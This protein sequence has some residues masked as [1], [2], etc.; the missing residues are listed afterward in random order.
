MSRH[1]AYIGALALALVLSLPLT[2]QD[3]ALVGTIKDA[4]GAVIS[5]AEITLTNSDTGIVQHTKSDTSGDYAFPIVKPGTYGVK[6]EQKGFHTFVQGNVVLAVEARA[7]LDATL[8]VGET[9][10]EITVAD[11]G[12]G[13][14]TETSSLGSVVE[15]KQIAEIPLNGRFFLDL[16]LLQAGTVVPSTN[17]RTFLAVPSGI[18]MSGINASGTREDSTNYLVDGINVSDMVQ[19]QI[20]FQPNI[21]MIQEFKVQTNAFSAEYGRNAGI[22]INAVSKSGTNSLHG[23][24]YEFLRNQRFDAKNFF[25]PAGPIIPFNRNIFGYSVGGP[26]I[27]NRTFFFSSYEGRRAHEV[28]SLKTQ[29]PSAA[30]RATVTN[31][32]IQKLLTLVPAATDSTGTFFIGPTP[33]NRTLNQFT[34]RIDHNI[35]DH[36]FLFGSFISNHDQRTEP[37]LQGN[38]LPGY[39]DF[40]PAKRYLLSLGY[41]HIFSSTIT[42]ELRAG[43]NRV[44]I[45]FDQ[46]YAGKPSDFGFSS[47]S[48]VFPEIEVSGG[49]FFGGI[50]GFPQGRGDTTFHYG[51]TV[52]LVKGK[53]SIKFGAE[54]RRFRNNN[55]NGG[56]GGSILFSSLATFLA[57]TPSQDIETALPA[58]PGL[59]VNALGTFAQDDIKLTRKLTLNLGIRWEYNGVPS[60]IH[61]RLS[62]FNTASDTVIQVGTNGVD[63]PYHKQFT[64]FGPRIGLAWDPLGDGKTVIRAGFGIY[65]DQPVTNLVSGLGSNPPFSQ[66]VNITSGITLATPFNAPAGSGSALACDRSQF[67]LW[68]GS[69]VQLQ[70]PARSSRHRHTGGLCRESGTSFAHHRRSESR[71]RRKAALYRLLG[72]HGERIGFRLQLQRHVDQRAEAARQ[73]T[74]SE[75]LLHLVPFHRQ[76]F[77]RK[78]QRASAELLQYFRRAG[79]FRFRRALPLRAE[80]DLSPALP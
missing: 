69:F 32:I 73:G 55:F 41:T 39:G 30:Q 54:F 68:A 53:H 40:R 28:A 35:S 65:Y 56:T 48:N 15:N 4:Q 16:A 10:T 14:Q 1:L 25:D 77:G 61:N 24:A 63:E 75:H 2:A 67:S 47:P 26:I 8:Q 52:S 60:E 3:A 46:F 21:D 44:R 70:R 36:D 33:R 6:V 42:N 38:N 27:R 31:P 79:V 23:T 74:Q 18:G 19:N 17:N 49:M 72:H 58:N 45:D 29:V 37:T 62:V 80:R 13:V 7:R 51:D 57:G 5:G 12:A 11:I 43:L 9:S 22:I 76:Q 20:T 78:L 71:R 64:A 50:T 34:G 59:R 66:A